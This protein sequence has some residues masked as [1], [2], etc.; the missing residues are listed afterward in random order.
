MPEKLVLVISPSYFVESIYMA[1]NCFP[2]LDNKKKNRKQIYKYTNPT[3]G[4]LD[5]CKQKLRKRLRKR[6]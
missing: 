6:T 3:R 5:F 1:S 2:N 4:I